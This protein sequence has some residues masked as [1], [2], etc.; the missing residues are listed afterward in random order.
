LEKLLPQE[1]AGAARDVAA[2]VV[3]RPDHTRKLAL[4]SGKRPT[5]LTSPL[6]DES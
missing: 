6:R 5:E 1:V 4:E 2:G 3:L